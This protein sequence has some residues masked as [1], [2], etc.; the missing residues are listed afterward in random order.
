MTRPLSAIFCAAVFLLAGK[1]YSEIISKDIDFENPELI[2]GRHGARIEIDG[3]LNIADPGDPS[4][5]AYVA[6]FALPPFEKISTVEITPNSRRKLEGSYDIAPFPRQA[7]TDRISEKKTYRNMNTYN[8]ATIYPDKPGLLV[9]E[10]TINGVRLAFL[11]IYPCRIIPSTGEVF[12]WGSMRVIIETEPLQSQPIRHPPGAA[13]RAG[14]RIETVVENLAMVDRYTTPAYEKP[15]VLENLLENR[16]CLDSKE[17]QP[18]YPYVIIT[19]EGLEAS[20]DEIVSLKNESGLRTRLVTVG[21][22]E[23]SFNGLDTQDR[24]RNFIKHAYFNWKAEYVLLGGDDEIIPHRGFYVKAGNEIET[25]IPSDLYYCSLDGTWNNDGDSYYGEPGE[26]DL[27]PELSLGRLPASS[28]EEISNFTNKITAYTLNPPPLDCS[29]ALMLGELLWQDEDT[30]TWGGDYKDEILLGSDNYDFET[31]GPAEEL[32]CA[33]LYDRDLPVPWDS[34]DIISIIN[35]GVNIINHLGH[36]GLHNVMRISSAHIPLLENNGSDVLP[37]VIYSQGCYSA[38]FDN[39]DDSG[40]IHQQDAIAEQLVNS[41]AG[42]VAYIGNTRLGWNAPGS[43]CGVSQFFDRQFF[44]AVF[45][46]KMGTTGAAFD[47]SRID[48]TAYIS[49]PLFRYVMYEMC[50]LGDP[51]MFIWTGRPS[52]L[53]ASYQPYMIPGCNDFTIEVESD[54]RP[55]KGASVSLF[56]TDFT[57]YQRGIT[58]ADGRAVF[59]SDISDS[60]FVQIRIKSPGHY[61]YS[62]SIPVDPTPERFL[63]LPFI[64]IDDDSLGESRGDGDGVIE[65]GE[66][67]EVGFAL[68]NKGED[69]EDSILVSLRSPDAYITVHDSICGPIFLPGKTTLIKDKQYL[70]EFSPEIPDNYRVELNFTISAPGGEW[71][72]TRTVTV[73]APGMSLDCWNTCDSL[74]GNGNG[75]VDAWEFINLDMVWTNNGSVDIPCPTLTL[76][77]PDQTYSMPYRSEIDLPGIAVGQTLVSKD[78]ISLFVKRYAPPFT[79][80]PIILELKQ[81]NLFSHAETLNVTVCGNNLEDH[82]DSAGFWTH[83]AEVGVDGWSIS[84]EEAYSTPSSWKCGGAPGEAYPNMMDAVLTSPPLCLYENSQLSFWH[85]IDAEA[86]FTYPYWAEDAGVV[87]ISTDG[88]DSWTIISP[89]DNYPCRASASNTIFLDPYQ[90]CYSGNAGWEFE[91]FDLSHISGPVLLR[92]HFAT[93]EQYGFGGWYID[94]ILISTENYTDSEGG[95]IPPSDLVNK[96]YEPTPNPFNPTTLIRFRVSNKSNVNLSIFDV[97]GKM[98]RTLIDE[99]MS[100][101]EHGIRWNGRDDRGRILASGVYFCRLSIGSHTSTRRLVLIR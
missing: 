8:L 83:R 52:D 93:N 61:L 66:K 13:L 20:F 24:I 5:P 98:V 68:S 17:D 2:R 41:P 21:W 38:A 97:S 99:Y 19:G 49:Y 100:R 56:N 63:D 16:S 3:C 77:I 54:G 36:A 31:A 32:A 84:S 22:I 91:E 28:P 45:G 70:M 55:V 40:T 11:K 95:E 34:N 14:R 10:Q 75:C 79:R 88:G 80:I 1:A 42:A 73:N 81:E 9:T 71:H 96:L 59:S 23:S 87:E 89:L 29:K 26:E 30:L 76:K 39:R 74:L 65:S 72:S 27:L 18:A 6:V 25:D 47:D 82:A 67:I 44:D 64:Q 69:P 101:G 62:D 35:Q 48:N 12:H 50:L 57:F 92:F 4:L 7:R 90:R 37:S 58:G 51:S 86:G 46:E 60:G 85:R 43:T 53:N 33:T 15:P 94:D 78:G